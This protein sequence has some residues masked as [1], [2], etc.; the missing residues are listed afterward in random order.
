[1]RRLIGGVLVLHGITH[2][3]VGI[4]PTTAGPAWF[5]T[6]LWVVPMI[7]FVAA[8]AGLIGA[9]GLDRHWLAIADVA[10]VASILLI[11]R[12]P[13]PATIFGSAVDGAVLIG[14]IPMV[15]EIVLRQIHI[16]EAVRLR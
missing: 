14:S 16:P 9:P 1:M 8:G 2:V 10:A 3:A 4:W 7:G 12:S 13:A 6:L 11:A 15:R 5:I